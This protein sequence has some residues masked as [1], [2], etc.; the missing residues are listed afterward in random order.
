MFSLVNDARG[1]LESERTVV[2]V[3]VEG[4]TLSTTLEGLKGRSP[5][6]FHPTLIL[7]FVI[8]VIC[9]AASVDA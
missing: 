3:G 1:D 8:S 7:C 2:D 4:G 5:V 9:A 6:V